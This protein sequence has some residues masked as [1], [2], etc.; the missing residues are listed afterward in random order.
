MISTRPTRMLDIRHPVALPGGCGAG[1]AELA[2]AAS[3]AG[4]LGM[5]GMIRMPPDYIRE[6]TCG[7]CPPVPMWRCST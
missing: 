4:G 5:L 3:N 1:G 6:Q 7:S 2:A